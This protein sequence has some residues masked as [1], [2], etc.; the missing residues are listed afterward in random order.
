MILLGCKVWL[1][2][3]AN[4]ISEQ[5]AMWIDFHSSLPYALRIHVGGVNAISGEPIVEDANTRL[6]LRNK[7]SQG[8]SVQDY[9]VLPEQPWLDG[10][11]TAPGKVRQFVAMPIGGGYTVEAQL[12]GAEIKAGIRFEIVPAAPYRISIKVH[13]RFVNQFLPLLL[14]SN[15]T[16]RELYE[17]LGMTPNDRLNG[18]AVTNMAQTIEKY[19]LRDGAIL[20]IARE[21]K[22]SPGFN[23]RERDMTIQVDNIS[24]QGCVYLKVSPE[25]TCDDVLFLLM[26]AKMVDSNKYSLCLKLPAEFRVADGGETKELANVSTLASLE[27]GEGDV[28]YLPT[29]AKSI[30]IKTLTGKSLIL[31]VEPDY[32]IESI[33]IMIQNKEGIPPDQQRLVFAGKQ[34]E[35][36]RSCSNSGAQNTNGS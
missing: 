33:K 2:T 4:I 3:M 25:D 36:E 32:S 13:E 31:N 15:T 24:H 27:I 29:P 14:M 7:L 34:L 17:Q 23:T 8:K 28:L 1:Q 30:T 35:G 12:T 10:I 19:G 16:V 21:P 26:D 22:R 18:S 20:T 6:R 9:V 5:E 11:A